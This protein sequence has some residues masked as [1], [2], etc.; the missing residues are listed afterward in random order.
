MRA[1][2][3]TSGV[4]AVQVVWSSRRGSHQIGHLGW[5][6]DDRGSGLPEVRYQ[7]PQILELLRPRACSLD[8][9]PVRA[10]AQFAFEV[11]GES[12][13]VSMAVREPV[14]QV[15]AEIDQ[16]HLLRR[17]PVDVEVIAVHGLIRV[18][19]FLAR[20]QPGRLSQPYRW[21]GSAAL[22]REVS[23]SPRAR[24]SL[25][26]RHMTILPR[27][28]SPSFTMAYARGMGGAFTTTSNLASDGNR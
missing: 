20:C 14:N 17:V 6:H 1:V 11:G 15:L 12:G 21:P 23:A 16:P 27:S 8:S 13:K 9:S 10:A 2:L 4:T 26:S 7:G 22:S 5:A 24:S 19:A 28:P 25:T 3:T 18:L